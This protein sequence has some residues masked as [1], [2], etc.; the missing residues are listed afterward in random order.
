M[1]EST[2]STSTPLSQDF[3]RHQTGKSF[4][5]IFWMEAINLNLFLV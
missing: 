4:A 2:S 3:D 1:Q 5:R